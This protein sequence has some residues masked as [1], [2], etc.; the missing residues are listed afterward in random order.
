MVEKGLNRIPIVGSN[1]HNMEYNS[2]SEPLAQDIG[3]GHRNTNARIYGVAS[4]ESG[5]NTPPN[6]VIQHGDF[7]TSSDDDRND[8]ATPPEENHTLVE[9]KSD[10]QHAKLYEVFGIKFK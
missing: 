8:H 4:M 10:L 5:G 7:F 6:D 3:V 1:M 2:I 9:D